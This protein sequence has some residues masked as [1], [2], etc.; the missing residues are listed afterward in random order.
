MCSPNVK[1][2]KSSIPQKPF[3]DEDDRDIKKI[4]ESAKITA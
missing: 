2:G 1:K 3:F 4:I